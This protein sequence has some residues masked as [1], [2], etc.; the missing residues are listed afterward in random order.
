MVDFCFGH[1][2]A[3]AV[4]QTESIFWGIEMFSR[5]TLPGRGVQ[6]PG[7]KSWDAEIG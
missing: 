2:L 3:P 4:F 1:S 7:L 6:V 5:F